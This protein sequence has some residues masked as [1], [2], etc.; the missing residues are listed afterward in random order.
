MLAEESDVWYCYRLILGREPDPSGWDHFRKVIKEETMM[1][2]E[3]GLAFILSDEFLSRH[4]EITVKKESAEPNE[5]T[6][7]I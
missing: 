4:P 3:L 1:P 2:E 7:S 6:D 5:T